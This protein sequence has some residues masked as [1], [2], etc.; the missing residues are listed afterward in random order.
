V[1]KP[2]STTTAAAVT[3]IHATKCTKTTARWLPAGGPRSERGP[4]LPTG[5]GPDR[6]T[7]TVTRLFSGDRYGHFTGS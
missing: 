7:V 1:A 2:A 3:K 6:V 5:D 4:R